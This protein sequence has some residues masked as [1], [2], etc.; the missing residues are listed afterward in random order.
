MT[1]A[2]IIALCTGLPTVIAA[3]T[4]AIITIL[5]RNKTIDN[6]KMIAEV[7]VLV[8]NQRDEMVKEI[9]GLKSALTVAKASPAEGNNNAT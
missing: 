9:A 6:G 7:H 3:L 2:D 8:N 4:A 1:T 5:N